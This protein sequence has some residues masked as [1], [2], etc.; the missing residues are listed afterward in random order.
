MSSQSFERVVE[1][2][3]V[4]IWGSLSEAIGIERLVAFFANEPVR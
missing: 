3:R 1:N 2:E 4:N